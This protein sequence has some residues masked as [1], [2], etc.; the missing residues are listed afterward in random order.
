M[1]LLDLARRSLAGI[2]TPASTRGAGGWITTV[3]EPYTGAW[4]VNAEITTETALSYSAVYACVSLI[5]QDIGKLALRLVEQDAAGIWTETTNP[6][7]SPVL[8]TPN[9]YQTIIKFIEGWITSKLVHGNTYVLKQRDARGVVNALYLL[10]PTRVTP[11]VAPDASV[12]YQ[13]GKPEAGRL[14]QLAGITDEAPVVPAS[15]M[16]HDLM[17][18]LFHPLVGVSP[19]YACGVSA[20]QGQTIQNNSSRFFANGSNPGGILVAPG[21]I[22]DAQAAR[23]KKRW[24]ERYSGPENIGRVAVMGDG[25]KYEPLTM[26]AVDAQLIDQ[27]KW[28]A[29]TICSTYHV[30]PYMVG[31]GP[32]PPYANVEPLIQLYYA[33]CLQSLIASFQACLNKGLE[34]PLY[35]GTRF[36]LTDLILMDASTRTKAAHEAINAG[37]LSPNEARRR[38]FG[39]GPVPGG[40]SPYLQ[41]QNYS[42]EALAARDDPTALPQPQPAADEDDAD[43]EAEFEAAFLAVQRA[44]LTEGLYD[45]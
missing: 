6:A 18:A 32:P 42:L 13:L 11:L 40:N 36:D 24:E 1:R 9:R 19:L 39:L 3:R 7:Y 10:D 26:T 38:Y 25:L 8:R 28:T 2:L 37:A 20:L 29:D 15:E 43:D 27:L 14:E 17:I 12:Y 22:D 45:G 44:A 41:V 35:L 5:A 16:I 31:I 30:P 21:P 23:L 33:G 4:Q 34:L